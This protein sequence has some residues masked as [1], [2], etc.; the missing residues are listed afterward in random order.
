MKQLEVSLN[1]MRKS[2]I[3]QN[4]M[5]LFKGAWKPFRNWIL[6]QYPV[7][8]DTDKLEAGLAAIGREYGS[9]LE[10]VD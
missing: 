7:E 3:L 8:R 4:P 9:E 5:T 10:S 2:Y 6:M 1:R